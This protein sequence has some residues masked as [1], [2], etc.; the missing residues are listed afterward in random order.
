ML[1]PAAVITFTHRPGAFLQRAESSRGIGLPPC[2]FQINHDVEA[3]FTAM[4]A[5]TLN[6]LYLYFCNACS[7]RGAP[8]PSD[9]FAPFPDLYLGIAVAISLKVDAHLPRANTLPFDKWVWRHIEILDRDPVRAPAGAAPITTIITP[10]C[11]R[12]IGRD[13]H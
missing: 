8:Y 11:R 5:V 12:G 1:S 10:I 2:A 13:I 6:W 4:E 3:M 7:Q 9:S